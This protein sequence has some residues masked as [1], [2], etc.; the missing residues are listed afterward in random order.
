MALFIIGLVIDIALFV[1]IILSVKGL[2]MR[3]DMNK[4]EG[5]DRI[6]MLALVGALGLTTILSSFGLVYMNGWN[7]NGGESVL[8]A[9]GSLLIG[10][11]V[12]LFTSS[13]GLFYW[14][15]TLEVKQKKVC[16]I[17][18][19]SAFAAFLLGLWVFSEGIANQDIYPLI[20]GFNFSTG[21]FTHPGE[22]GGFQIKFY[23][24]VIV[25][26]A[27]IC[28]F[29][30]D[31]ETYKKF[32]EHGL[33]D[34]LFI[35][36]FLC[37]L[38]GSRLWY[39]LILEPEQF[40][41]EPAT[42]FT[43]IT[44]GGLAI[45]GGALFGMAGGIAFVLIFRKYIDVRFLM[46][47]AIPTILIAQVMGRW[48]N[49]FNQEVYG[50]VAPDWLV[51]MLP[52]IVKNNMFIRG[53]Y[54]VPLFLIEGLINIGGFC[55]IR[56]VFGRMQIFHF[57]TGCQSALYPIWYGLVRVTLEPLREGFTLQVGSSEAF[58]YMQSWITGFAMIALGIVWFL[59]MFFFHKKRMQLGLEDANGDKIK[60]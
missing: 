59:F 37:G 9:L 10:L 4:I 25:C 32:G 29:I 18:I 12:G 39:C 45:Q 27:L 17:L 57:G 60:K 30:T 36:A 15:P 44:D 38:I 34:T 42:I 46:D 28:Y 41:A 40:L 53:E 51:N 47:V 1:Y 43:K 58:G 3:R 50:G 55:L 13:F 49:F 8:V 23:G 6:K 14:K 19:Y 48:G 24:I 54:R 31:H 20:N 56:F 35:V 52:T 11:G 5:K 2:V 33:I 16:R 26:G 22:Y 7:L 21:A